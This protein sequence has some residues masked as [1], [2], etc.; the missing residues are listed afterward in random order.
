[1]ETL[2][3]FGKEKIPDIAVSKEGHADSLVGH[4]KTHDDWFTWGWCNYNQYCQL[5]KQNSPY[6]LR[7]PCKF[8]DFLLKNLGS[9]YI[10]PL[11]IKTGVKFYT[12]DKIK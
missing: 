6:L 2:R 9:V 4:K 8:E 1:M 10:V 7:D 11:G 12:K 5:L 3:L